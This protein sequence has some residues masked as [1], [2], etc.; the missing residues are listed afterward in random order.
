[1]M[2][3]ARKTAPKSEVPFKRQ[4][5]QFASRPFASRA[6]EGEDL[7]GEQRIDFS[8]A[9]IDIFP[10]ETVQ[11]KRIHVVQ[12]GQK[13]EASQV[14]PAIEEARPNSTGMP[15]GLKSNLETLSGMDLSGVRVHHKSF[16][17]VQLNALAYT[18]GQEIYVAPGQ[19]RHLPHEAWHVVQ[20]MQG[21]VKPTGKV[22]GLPLNDSKT[23][24][25]EADKMGEQATKQMNEGDGNRLLSPGIGLDFFGSSRMI[26]ARQ[27]MGLL[28]TLSI[29]ELVQRIKINNSGIKSIFGDHDTAK[30]QEFFNW[31]RKLSDSKNVMVLDNIIKTL[32]IEKE[33][34]SNM[35]LIKNEAL[36]CSGRIKSG[37]D[38]YLGRLCDLIENKLVVLKQEFKPNADDDMYVIDLQTEDGDIDY[39]HRDKVFPQIS[40]DEIAEELKERE[41]L[42]KSERK[43][44]PKGRLCKI[45]GEEKV[46]IESDFSPLDEEYDMGKYWIDLQTNDGKP[47]WYQA[48]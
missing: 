35:E 22:D 13:Q 1:M 28:N 18:Q 43:P 25:H 2:T 40:L 5:S 19:D 20:Q 7:A 8:L 34:D 10:R 41:K 32:E 4:H 23:L 11:P 9:D 16:K 38:P 44:L 33:I 14:L 26:N 46:I 47:D 6:S 17:P 24:E 36:R 30:F 27:Q 45:I 39:Y 29:G 48:I 21:R 15:D 31:I 42:S 3:R 37:R 12:Q